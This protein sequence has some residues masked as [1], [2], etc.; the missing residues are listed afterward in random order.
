MLKKLSLLLSALF[1]CISAYAQTD[2]LSQPVA[3]SRLRISLLTCGVGDQEIYE[4]FGHTG[5][6]IVDSVRGTDRVYSYGTFNYDEGF[7]LKFMRGKLLYYIT[8]DSFPFFMEEYVQARRKVEEQVVMLPPAAKEQIQAY[9]IN[10]ALPENR[11]YKYDFFFDNCATR[12]RDIFPRALGPAFKFGQTM[13]PGSKITFRDIINKYLARKKWER[14]GI[15]LLL[16][17]KIDKVMSNEDIMFLPDYLREGIG[18]ATVNGQKVATDPVLILPDGVGPP[19][20]VNQPFI[21]TATI[22]LLTILG[23]TVK[24]LKLLGKIMTFILLFVTGL[25]GCLM[26]FMWVGTDHQ[27]CQNNFNILWAL[28]TNLVLAFV[29]KNK[30]RYALIAIILLLVGLLLHFF[31]VQKMQLLELMPLLVA[32][33]FV[34]GT[35][36]RRPLIKAS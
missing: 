13:P 34:Y 20:G 16:G 24:R 33:L 31:G 7:E 8:A 21:L 27:A 12:I 26:F 23:L 11:Y 32:L 15:N 19:P 2:S 4:V 18:N 5:V 36:Y 14:F 6:R 29:G 9:L 28:P 1:V 22:A 10:N 3:G 30:S 25:L 17:S 35:I